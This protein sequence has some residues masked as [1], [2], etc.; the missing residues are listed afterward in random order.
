[1]AIVLTV[2]AFNFLGDGLRDFLDPRINCDFSR[3]ERTL[4][5]LRPNKGFHPLL[6]ADHPYVFIDSCMQIWPDADFPIAHRHGVTAY[7]VTAFRPHDGVA[8]AL[9]GLM[10]W[11][12]VAR[13]HPNLLVAFRADDIRNAKREGSAALIIS[14]K[15]ASGSATSCIASRLSPAWACG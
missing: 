3:T 7:A 14:P 13:K 11:H 4:V 2:L 9:E 12:L 10:F 15:E 5:T 1:M 6:D 8:D